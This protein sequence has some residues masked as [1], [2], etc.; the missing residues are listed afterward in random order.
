MSSPMLS[1][2]ATLVAFAPPAF[3]PRSGLLRLSASRG[4]RR[5]AT[6]AFTILEIVIVLAIIGLLVGVAV[7]DLTKTFNKSKVQIAK[8]FVTSEVEIPLTTYRVDMGDFP[9]AE[10]G[11]LTALWVAPSSK[12]D[13]WH[14]PYAK[15][16]K[17]PPDPWGN[18]YQYRYPGSHNKDGYDLWSLGPGGEEG[19][20][21]NIGNW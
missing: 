14:G 2:P 8:L 5:T 18:P 1:P 17:A 7:T 15:G 3:G 6:S 20:A 9:S 13:R 19:S 12:A 10:D 4:L 21:N 16:S 11:G